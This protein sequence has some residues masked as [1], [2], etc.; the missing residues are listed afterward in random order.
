MS[1]QPRRSRARWLEGAPKALLACYDSGPKTP[2]RY[3]A[4]YGKPLWNERMGNVVPARFMSADPF[5]PQ[6]FG[7][8]GEHP[9]WDRKS[10]GKKV[11]FLDLPEKVRKCIQYDCSEEE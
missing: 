7:M 4:L 2:D 11:R 1:Y 3:T 8:F 10:L 6:G 5:H 9:S